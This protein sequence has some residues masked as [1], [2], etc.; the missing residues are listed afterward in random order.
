[1]LALVLRRVVT[2]LPVFVGVIF[3]VVLIVRLTPGVA[4]I[5]ND[6]TYTK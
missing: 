4:A 2:A 3:A 1:M 5:K 6:L